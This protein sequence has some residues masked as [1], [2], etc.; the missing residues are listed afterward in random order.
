MIM[1]GLN[2]ELIGKMRLTECGRFAS[3]HWELWMEFQVKN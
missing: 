2:F 3:D 1:G